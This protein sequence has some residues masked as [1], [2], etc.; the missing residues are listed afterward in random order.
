MIDDPD[1]D[2][3]ADA[4]APESRESRPLDGNPPPP[5]RRGPHPLLV[6]C[7]GVATCLVATVAF[8]VATILSG[9]PGLAYAGCVAVVLALFA[10][11]LR[12]RT[13][14]E[15]SAIAVGAAVAL[16]IVGGCL[17]LVNNAVGGG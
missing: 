9:H 3:T 5:A 10:V 2:H 4:N 11:R 12:R 17:A 14:P 16:V 7:V 1:A 8:G 13:A 6:G 15:L